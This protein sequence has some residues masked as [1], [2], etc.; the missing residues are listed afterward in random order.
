M[1]TIE[2][3]LKVL[4][5]HNV[6]EEKLIEVKKS[7]DL[8]SEIHKNQFRQSGEP[9]IIHPLHVANNLLKMEIYDPDSISAALLHDTIED[10]EDDF[11]KEDIAKIINPEV[12][13]LVDGV[14]KMR[15]MNFSTRNDQNLANT[16]KIIN[17]LTKD[18][19]II[20]I[21]LADRIHNMETLDFK[22][23]EK[24][25]ENAIETMKLFV[26]LSLTIGAYQVKNV[27]EDLS[28]QYIEP[29]EYKRIKEEKDILA[30][31]EESYLREMGYKIREILKQK[32]IPNDIILRTQTITTIYKKIK[33]GYRLENIYDLFYLKLLVD[34][35]E[36]CY[37]TLCAVHSM[38]PPINGRFKDYIFNPRTNLYQS[39]HT[40]VSDTNGKLIKVKIRTFDMD[41]VAAYGIPAL[42]NIRDA[43]TKEETQI[44]LREK[45]QF[46]KKLIELDESF[47]NNEDFFREINSELLTE[48]V[49]AYN[50]SGEIIELPAGST[51][52]DFACQVFPDSL[53]IMTGVLVNGK[54]VPLNRPLK[55]NDR[56]QIITEGK[57]NHEN[58]EQFAHTSSAKQKIKTLNGQ[59]D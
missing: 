13:E 10:A 7:F 16:R 40:T 21:K 20:L 11:S 41:K 36:E 9:Y 51:A 19:R 27:L 42:W 58:W 45:C 5:E 12:A 39:L 54:E 55:N 1:I 18:V 49:Y 43:K 30:E 32:D 37:Q 28:L 15:R 6:S 56:V 29:E 59:S 57:I 26:P 52:L 33:K 3:I 50:H 22:S 46:A 53:D 2:K 47:E 31:T 8:A 48:H 4:R 24:Q 17:G 38:N 35:I 44:E 23:P 34:E 14:T 25:K